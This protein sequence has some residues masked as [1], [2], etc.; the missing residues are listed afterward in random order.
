MAATNQ[1]WLPNT[2]MWLNS[3]PSPSSNEKPYPPSV[4]RGWIGNLDFYIHLKVTRQAHCLPLL[5]QDQRKLAKTEGLNNTQSPITHYKNIQVSVKK[6]THHTKNEKELQLNE[7]R[8]SID[9]N[10]KMTEMLELSDKD[11]KAAMIKI[12][13][14]A[15]T[16]SLET[17]KK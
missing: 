4:N 7:K 9:D 10:A 1:R 6:I 13:Q 17:N 12:L 3:N 2:E 11:F 8:Q 5:E 14:Q 16:N 15:I